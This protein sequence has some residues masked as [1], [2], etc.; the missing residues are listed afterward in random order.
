MTIGT[1]G[2]AGW[3][4]GR[5]RV[6]FRLRPSV[7][8]CVACMHSLDD[9]AE[10]LLQRLQLSRRTAV[11]HVLDGGATGFPD[12]R[13]RTVSHAVPRQV[14]VT[15]HGSQHVHGSGSVH[16]LVSVRSAA[17]TLGRRLRS[18][19]GFQLLRPRMVVFV[20]KQRGQRVF[21]FV[22]VT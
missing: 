20:F 17:V 5:E 22:A 18:I 15:G 13:I 7:E 4:V 3:L 19:D 14:V 10:L 6:N 9:S 21:V 1:C 16:A 8:C 11:A 2:R 12:V